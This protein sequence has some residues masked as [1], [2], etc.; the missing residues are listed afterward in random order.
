MPYPKL[1]VGKAIIDLSP[2]LIKLIREQVPGQLKGMTFTE[3]MELWNAVK[4]LLTVP[5]LANIVNWLKLSGGGSGG[6]K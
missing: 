1:K 2:S 5:A 6:V 4:Q 3:M